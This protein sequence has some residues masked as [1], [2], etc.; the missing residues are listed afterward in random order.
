[1]RLKL[2]PSGTVTQITSKATTVI[3][4]KPCGQITTH[5]ASLAATTSVGFTVTNDYI[6]AGDTV[7]LSLASGATASSY[8]YM[9]DAIAAGS[10]IIHIRNVTAGALAEAL[11][12]NFSIIKNY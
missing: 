11:V 8:V 7:N 5:A 10:F 3:I 1:M 4:N 6:A 2:S 12:I 9:A